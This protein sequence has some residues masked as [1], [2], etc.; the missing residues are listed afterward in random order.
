MIQNIWKFIW[1]HFKWSK[2]AGKLSNLEIKLEDKNLSKLERNNLLNE[3]K[4]N[5]EL[6]KLKNNKRNF[7]TEYRGSL[8]S[9]VFFHALKVTINSIII[10]PW[11]GVFRD[12]N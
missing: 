8:S 12:M 11:D 4:L 6:E 7:R 5:K 9:D 10:K 3:K 2:Y 1:R